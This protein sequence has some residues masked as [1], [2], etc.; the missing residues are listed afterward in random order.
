M[1]GSKLTRPKRNVLKQGLSQV[2]NIQSEVDETAGSGSE[3]PFPFLSLEISFPSS[4][5][6]TQGA[7]SLDPIRDD[8]FM[9]MQ[10]I[11]TWDA[12]LNIASKLELA[13]CQ[14]SG[15]N[16][17]A[18]I[19]SL[20]PSLVPTLQ[21]R[22]VPHKP[23]VDMILWPSMRDRIL[24]SPSAINETQ[25]LCDVTSSDI[26]V[27]GSTPWDPTGWEVSANFAKRWW[28]LMD[29]GII[30]TANFWRSQRGEKALPLPST[31]PAS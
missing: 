9:V 7:L 11:D 1:P 12:L 4:D 8:G 10:Q 20:P 5:L 14:D 13:C 15:F 22:V 19:C 25:F 3:L 31:S 6:K 17:V 21:Q 30:Q 28:F 27:W 2:E 23:Y 26:R 18:P 16:I 24:S 29:D